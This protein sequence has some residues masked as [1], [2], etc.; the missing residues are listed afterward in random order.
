MALVFAATSLAL[1]VAGVA[2]SVIGGIAQTKAGK[3]AA[4]IA[5]RDSRLEAAHLRDIARVAADDKRRETRRLIGSQQVAFAA[6]GVDTQQGTPLDVLG[7]TVVESE[8]AAL[9]IAAGFEDQAAAVESGGAARAHALRLQS[10][11]AGIGTILGAAGNLAQI[12][13]SFLAGPSNPRGPSGFTSTGNIPTRS[14]FTARPRVPHGGPRGG[15]FIGPIQPFIIP[16]LPLGM[17]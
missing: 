11:A 17:R 14:I 10:R 15:G 5:E 6:A 1:G 16:S 13:G 2:T 7:D 4:G 12:G 9:R 8:L 3:K